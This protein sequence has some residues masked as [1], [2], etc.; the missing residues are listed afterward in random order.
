MKLSKYFSNTFWLLAS[1]VY[2]MGF[3]LAITIWMARYL[4]PEQFGVLN[5]ALS[6]VILFSVLINLG[7][8]NVVV[9]QIV[10][11]GDFEGEIVASSLFLRL[12]GSVAFF[13]ITFFFVISVKP[14]DATVHNLVLILSIGYVFKAFEILRYWFEAYVRAKYSAI[15]EGAIGA[16]K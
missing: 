6:F 9:K 7:L 10:N 16:S 11:N 3:A 8:E 5:Y 14:D 12:I 13:I 15:M 1:K 2:R 4:G